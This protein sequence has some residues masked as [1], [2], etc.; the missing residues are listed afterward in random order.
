MIQWDTDERP[1][2]LY[3]PIYVLG[4]RLCRDKRAFEGAEHTLKTARRLQENGDRRP[5][6]LTRLV[7]RVSETEQHGML[8]WTISPRM[9]GC[10]ARVLYVHG[11]G[12]VHPVTADYWR[13]VRALP[14][15]PAEVT[16]PAYPL[17]RTTRVTAGIAVHIRICVGHRLGGDAR[18][19]SLRRIFRSRPRPRTNPA[20]PRITS[21][22]HGEFG[23]TSASPPRMR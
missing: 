9:G 21:H 16:V 13:L 2:T 15:A 12:Y 14:R 4:M 7:S 22:A 6:A 5:R 20:S 1:A 18:S 11:G 3:T 8:S 10:R 23:K 17:G 19:K